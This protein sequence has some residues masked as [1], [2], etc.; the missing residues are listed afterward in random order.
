MRSFPSI[1]GISEHDLR[2]LYHLPLK[3]AAARLG[4]YEG[5]LI[6]LCRSRGIPKWPY[7]Q[8]AKIQRKLNFL[9]GIL[10]K[11]DAGPNHLVRVR[12]AHLLQQYDAIK[13]WTR[14]SGHTMA[15]LCHLVD[16][17]DSDDAIELSSPKAEK[18]SI[19][20]ILNV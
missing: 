7:R 4:S 12:R 19:A 17:D 6:R 1:R 5:A 8:L 11:M 16:E 15:E 9:D 10:D 20:F 3:E 13:Y 18:L 14:H 2:E